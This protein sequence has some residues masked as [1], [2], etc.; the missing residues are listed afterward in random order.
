MQRLDAAVF[1]YL[2]R[3]VCHEGAVGLAVA[4]ELDAAGAG[5]KACYEEGDTVQVNKMPTR[6]E[7]FTKER[8]IDLRHHHRHEVVHRPDGK[9][10][11]Q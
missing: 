1:L 3:F 4:G 7:P 10:L 9:G 8:V 11:S 6:T 2:L 5:D